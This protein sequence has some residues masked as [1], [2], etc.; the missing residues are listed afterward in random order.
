MIVDILYYHTKY[1]KVKYVYYFKTA[2]FI[3]FGFYK[4]D[5]IYVCF[6]FSVED[7]LQ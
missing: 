1:Y 2:D 6:Y 7:F 5:I 3:I 4:S